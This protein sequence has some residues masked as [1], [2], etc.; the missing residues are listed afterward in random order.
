M[1]VDEDAEKRYV[2][3]EIIHV[4]RYSA[5]K[6]VCTNTV[7]ETPFY[8]KELEDAGVG[9]QGHV[10]SAYDTRSHPRTR[11][12]IKKCFSPFGSNSKHTYREIRLLTHLRHK[13]IIKLLDLFSPNQHDIYMVFEHLDQ[14]LGQLSRST[15]LSEK[16]IRSIIFQILSGLEYMHYA[17]VVHRDLKPENVLIGHDQSVKICDFGLARMKGP[18]MT[19]ALASLHYRSPEVL[20]G[21]SYGRPHDLWGVGCIFAELFNKRVLFVGSNE[22]EQMEAI[23]TILGPPSQSFLGKFDAKTVRGLTR[24]MTRSA[25]PSTSNK[26][27]NIQTHRISTLPESISEDEG[28]DSLFNSAASLSSSETSGGSISP[29]VG[30]PQSFS[31]PSLSL[32]MLD[33]PTEIE[34]TLQNVVP[35]ASD[36]ALDLIHRLL[37]Y[38][39]TTRISASE[40]LHHSFFQGPS[41]FD[42]SSVSKK[43]NEEDY[44][45]LILKHVSEFVSPPYL[46]T[47]KFSDP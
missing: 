12:A 8:Y 20:L 13:N 21:H 7:F 40:A 1:D 37:L 42:W 23:M 34:S 3:E 4:T 29:T 11:V 27:R 32:A 46:Q 35:K 41:P 22:I 30:I 14:N 39:W 38:D 6:V 45:K 5:V 2:R 47:D 25:S 28:E 9:A 31:M 17:G 16:H 33:S 44:K 36:L 18:R 19:M 15:N 24:C 43:R 10:V 26:I